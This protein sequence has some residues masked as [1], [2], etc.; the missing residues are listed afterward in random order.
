MSLL[1]T[2]SKGQLGHA[3]LRRAAAAGV[4]VEG[5]DLPEL[6]ILDT[7]AVGRAVE[8][9]KVVINAAAYTAVDKAESEIVAAYRANR[10]GPTVLADACA[11]AGAALIHISTDYVFDGAKRRPYTERDVPNPLSVYGASKAEGEDAIE[12]RLG[13]HVILRTGWLF[14][15]FGNNFVRTMLKLA[16]TRDE[17]KVVTDQTGGPT[18]ADALADALLAIAAKVQTRGFKA[19]GT[20]HF[21]GQPATTWAGFAEAIFA[22][23]PK[24]PRVLPTTTADWAAPAPRPLYSALDCARIGREF[25]I[26]APDWR[27][28]L[29]A[30]LAELKAGQ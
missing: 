7:E 9:R 28:G 17:L 18:P 6:D 1:L 11:A 29:K 22:D 14:S 13:R 2:G 19:W 21:G 3:L 5:V 15:A 10:D 25:G 30:V 23:L 27:E 26:K 16:A 4:A 12:D 20:Y 24:R 8:G